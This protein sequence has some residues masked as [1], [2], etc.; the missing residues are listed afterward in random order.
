MLAVN[1][2][3]RAYLLCGRE[4]GEGMVCFLDRIVIEIRMISILM[5]GLQMLK[6]EYLG[7]MSFQNNSALKKVVVL[8][9]MDMYALV[10][11]KKMHACEYVH[12]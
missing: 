3:I 1:R 5:M 4:R 9:L 8:I 7:W 12:Y 10:T 2:L 11:T 6:R